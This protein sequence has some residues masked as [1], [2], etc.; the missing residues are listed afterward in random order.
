MRTL[1]NEEVAIVA[2][3]EIG[4]TLY[5]RTYDT[6]FEVWGGGQDK[7]ATYVKNQ[8]YLAAAAEAQANG[9]TLTRADFFGW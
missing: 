2:G 1:T 6:Y 3:G 9:E 7:L 8:A 5:W 4:F